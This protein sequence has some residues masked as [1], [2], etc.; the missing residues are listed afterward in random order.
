MTTSS[1]IWLT[2]TQELNLEPHCRSC[3][4]PNLQGEV[5]E[6]QRP[7]YIDSVLRMEQSIAAVLHN[8]LG[9]CLTS[10]TFQLLRNS[11]VYVEERDQDIGIP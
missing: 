7:E 10:A 3:R 8:L 5:C 9:T 1:L 11:T 6:E 4:K 2:R